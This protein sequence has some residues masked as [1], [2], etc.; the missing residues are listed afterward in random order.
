MSNGKE[1]PAEPVEYVV[2]PRLNPKLTPEEMRTLDEL[3]AVRDAAEEG[4]QEITPKIP[5][6]LRDVMA[7]HEKFGITYEGKPRI[8]PFDLA[9]FRMKFSDEEG[10]EYRDHAGQ[11]LMAI[12]AGDNVEV[13]HHLEE[14]LDALVDKLYV[15]LGTVYLHGLSEAFYTAWVRVHRANMAKVRCENVA[16][17]TRG[18]T[19]DVI[20]PEGWLAPSHTDL[21][22]DHA[23]RSD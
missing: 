11:G 3:L 1:N 15:D 18:S 21:V 6:L 7:F 22:E 4:R 14:I 9:E 8:L 17:S 13:T 23:H 12:A 5:E 2:T 20:K 19:Y 16:D 10:A